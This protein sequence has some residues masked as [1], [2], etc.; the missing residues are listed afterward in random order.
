MLTRTVSAG[1]SRSGLS[2]GV[3]GD[4]AERR[5]HYKFRHLGRVHLSGPGRCVDHV[6]L[7]HPHAL[8]DPPEEHFRGSI[9]AGTVDDDDLPLRVSLEPLTDHVAQHEAGAAG[10]EQGH[11][12]SGGR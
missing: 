3:V 7:D 9:E 6:G 4:G 1:V 8:A 10:D 11:F 5:T 2:A 12:D